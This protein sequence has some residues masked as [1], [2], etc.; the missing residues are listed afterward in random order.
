MSTSFQQP[1]LLVILLMSI[2]SIPLIA[3]EENSKLLGLNSFKTEFRTAIR[4][5]RIFP[6]WKRFLNLEYSEPEPKVKVRGRGKP[7]M[8]LD[9]NSGGDPVIPRPDA[10][11]K[12]WPRWEYVQHLIWMLVTLWLGERWSQSHISR[13]MLTAGVSGRASARSP[14]RVQVKWTKI[15]ED[16]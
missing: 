5:S 2:G 7:L 12:D 3:I 1:E 9:T 13:E 10:K 8:L 6:L 4:V 14:D 15:A 16:L 11:V